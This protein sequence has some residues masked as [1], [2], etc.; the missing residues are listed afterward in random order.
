VLAGGITLASSVTLANSGTLT[1]SGTLI[2]GGTITGVAL[3]VPQLELAPGGYLLNQA[4]GVIV[5]N[6]GFGVYGQA[7]G[8]STVT[9]LG[10]IA[11]YDGIGVGVYLKGGGSVT[12]ASAGALLKGS[13]DGISV[14]DAAGTVINSGS[15]VGLGSLGNGVILLSG[16]TVT[17][18]AGGVI[19]GGDGI[20]MGGSGTVLNQGSITGGTIDG[21]V[22]LMSSGNVS[23][24]ATGVISGAAYGIGALGVGT[25][26]NAGTIRATGPSGIGVTLVSG[27][28][29][30]DSGTIAGAT[31]AVAFGGTGSNLLIL[32]HG[33]A[34]S[35]GVV[36][37]A[38]ASDTV[39]LLGTSA[40]NAV[41]ATYNTLGLTNVGTIAF[42]PDAGNYAT[43]DITNDT[44]LPG[45]IAGF[46]GVHDTIDLTGLSDVG[47]DASTS[48]N[49]LTNVLTVTGDNGSV[50]LQL[51]SE[52]YTGVAWQALNDGSNGTDV[53]PLCFC[54]GTYLAT[55]QGEER[56]ERLKAGDLVL[57]ASGESRPIAWVGHGRV[58]ATRG[59]R[60]AAT[61]VIVRK[62][63]IAP[64]VPHSDLHVT[65]GHSL[66][67][68]GVLVPVEFLVNHRTILWDDHAQEVT[69][70]HVELETHDVLVANGVPAESYRDDGNRWLFRNANAGWDQPPK[71]PCA[72]VVT[73]G[74]IVNALWLRLLDR[75]GARP[76]RVLTDDPDLHLLVDGRR[77][78][79][80]QRIGS[81]YVFSLPAAARSVR[82]ASRAA[83]PGELGLARDPRVLGVPLRRIVV[84]AGNRFRIIGV[85][86]KRLAEDFHGYESDG[87]LRWTDG[88][89]ALPA[90]LFMGFVGRTEVVLH[91]EG[92]T[93]YRADDRSDRSAA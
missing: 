19:S 89:A 20:R 40:A 2:N 8:A 64:N 78:D 56:V 6:A 32:E 81:A 43:L 70:Y 80:G 47:N 9:N 60:N 37:S 4:T 26:T 61:P 69:L 74:P 93:Q 48:F 66:F 17:N 79:A 51:D 52:N 16:G 85:S 33:Y 76:H 67:L 22:V 31:T 10:T 45:T 46:T 38:S 65:K 25:V 27:G 88:D 59:R 72:E 73:G 11:G 63:A 34:L 5:Q 55:P 42:A 87:D 49:T 91:V 13:I 90:D 15:I 28:A 68:D 3:D 58:L 21:G 86:D 23:N 39:E 77:L 1:D 14:I 53:A 36:G 7:S 82:I 54:A 12:N 41:T 92:T 83:A 18:A 57:T 75:A 44:A 50:Q 30:I 24:A 29:V 84:R 35:G 62:R 71:P